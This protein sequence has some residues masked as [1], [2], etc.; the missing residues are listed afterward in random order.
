[1][2]GQSWD[3]SLCLAVFK[4]MNAAACYGLTLAAHRMFLAG[5]V[6]GSVALSSSLWTVL[7]PSPPQARL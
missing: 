3:H 5:T 1:M 6:I 2:T 7:V 4:W